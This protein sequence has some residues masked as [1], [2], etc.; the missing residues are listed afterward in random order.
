MI[1][2]DKNT[3]AAFYIESSAFS[4]VKKIASKVAGDLKLVTGKSFEITDD[5]GKFSKKCPRILVATMG[6]SEFLD[7]L[8]AKNFEGAKA[9]NSGGPKAKNSDGSKAKNIAASKAENS[10]SLIR[11]LEQ[12][13]GKWECYVFDI[14]PAS[15]ERDFDTL[16]I[17]GSDKRGTIYGLFH[18]SEIAGVS[19]WVWF[20]DAVPAKKD[21]F[22]IKKSDC[23]VSKEPSVRYRGFFI[24]D[25]WPS[26]GNWS[27]DH[28][29]GFTTPMYEHVFE[30]LLRLKGNYLWPAMWSSNFSLDGPGL[31]N[32]ELADELGVVMSNSHHEPCLRHSEEWD[33]VKGEN[34]PYGTAWNFDKNREGLTNYW[35]DGL[36]RNGRFEN[37]ITMG[38]RGE[39]DSEVLGAAA[40]LKDNIDYLKDVI[41]TQNGLIRET[42][43]ENLDETRRMLAIYKEVEKYFYG[44]KDTEGLKEWDGLDGITCMLCEDNFGNLRLLP[45]KAMKER[46]GGWGMYYH[47]DYHGGPI[48][49]EW[50]NSTHLSRTCEQMSEA[51]DYGV[52]EI[53]VVNVGDL[54]PQ[55]LP[56]SYFLDL[57]YDI[58]KWGQENKNAVAE[59]TAKWAAEQFP[60]LTKKQLKTVSELLD[61]YTKLNSIRRPEALSPD[62]Y[63][64]TNYGEA[65]VMYALADEIEKKAEKLYGELKGTKDESSY[66]QLV[67]YPATASANLIKLQITA[68]R[69]QLYAKA[70]AVIA[71]KLALDM[72][73]CVKRDRK[74]TEDY[75][76]VNGGKWSGMMLSE[77]IGFVNWNDEECAYPV[78]MYVEPANKPRMIVF[79]GNSDVYTAGGDWTGKKLCI[80]EMIDPFVTSAQIHIL[81][82]SSKKFSYSIS[83][84]SDWL[85]VVKPA[86][87][88]TEEE[89]VTVVADRK[90]M[91]AENMKA[92]L[93]VSTEFAHV[94]INVYV[95][96]NAVNIA[97]KNAAENTAKNVAKN[98]AEN[99][100]KN[101]AKN[102]ADNM[103]KN[104]PVMPEPDE[105]ALKELKIYADRFKGGHIVNELGLTFEMSDADVL[106]TSE[107]EYRLLPNFGKFGTGLKAFP[108]DRTFT[109]GADAP[110]AGFDFILKKA[111]KI[112]IEIITAPDNPVY[113]GKLNTVGISLNGKLSEVCMVK[114]GYEGGENSCRQWAEG[115]LNQ[116]H[117]SAITLDG[118]EGINSLKIYAADPGVVLE[119]IRIRRAGSEWAYGYLKY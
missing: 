88:V 75:H 7:S 35:R 29:G 110:S 21:L 47:F 30:L 100:A 81:N 83:S 49:Y 41:T 31:S 36:K 85:K 33:M 92:A 80:T 91:P 25:E 9:K 97:K 112:S 77:H 105:E 93:R 18:L 117:V 111:G 57:A 118:S 17:A 61:G 99:M 90:K 14:I 68:G 53:W 89:Y 79:A 87:T 74:L 78:K 38:M 23:M 5:N 45:E 55:E 13:E 26:F 82:G 116:E 40:T 104:V 109:P 102:A 51:Y 11:K 27:R 6:H 43:S 32:A 39:R 20:A 103:A 44:D 22:E 37:I 72:E 70:G 4:G 24:N 86:G 107:G 65:A 76:R 15:D 28:F 1:I 3:K 54:K 115:V 58:D 34:T 62:T 16:L 73:Y 63:H 98:S 119:R 2:A 66:Y 69:N 71:N 67:Y 50:I 60:E 108:T 56:L 84:D 12:I 95:A 96:K 42:I 46:K 10:D 94:D 19:P 59:Y 113:K 48:S 101:V 8:K 64:P 52:R 106:N 114:E